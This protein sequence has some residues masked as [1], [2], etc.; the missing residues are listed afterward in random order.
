MNYC[1]L[2]RLEWAIAGSKRMR[3]A[4]VGQAQPER[5]TRAHSHRQPGMPLTKGS[6]QVADSISSCKAVRSAAWPWCCK[7]LACHLQA[8]SQASANSGRHVSQSYPRFPPPR[9]GLQA[10]SSSNYHKNVSKASAFAV[11]MCCGLENAPTI[12]SLLERGIVHDSQAA[13]S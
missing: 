9:W 1:I 12:A 11:H 6:N 8:A 4:R 3:A 2:F 10:K 7:D 13:S 5:P